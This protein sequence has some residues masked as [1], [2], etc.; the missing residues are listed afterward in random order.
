[1]ISIEKEYDIEIKRLEK[2]QEKR[3]LRGYFSYYFGESFFDFNKEE[4]EKFLPGKKYK[5]VFNI[6]GI[7]DFIGEEEKE[8]NI[9]TW[10]FCLEKII[11][12]NNE[13]IFENKKR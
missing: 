12:K 5:G 8:E 3:K 11:N 13:V 9:C 10:S 7:N 6:S 4:L 2:S 1:M